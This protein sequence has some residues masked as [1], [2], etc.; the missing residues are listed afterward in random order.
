MT[1]RGTPSEM[2]RGVV[3]ATNDRGIKLSGRW[4]NYSQFRQ[5]TRP[6]VG[7]EVEV[8]V[9]RDRFINALT[10]VGGEPG[11]LTMELDEGMSG[12]PGG[13]AFEGFDAPPSRGGGSGAAP[14][15]ARPAWR[16]AP[17]P[18][19]NTEIRRLAL[20]KAAADYAAGR[21]DLTPDDVLAVARGWE[22]WIIE[23]EGD[24]D[25]AEDGA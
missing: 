2:L 16:S 15:P 12:A 7:Q 11:D 4:L 20:I 18:D 21:P 6:Q 3:E 10:V 9:E 23:R 17:V 25:R 13:D 19:R 14:R 1:Q 8:E 22:T 24:A 5:V